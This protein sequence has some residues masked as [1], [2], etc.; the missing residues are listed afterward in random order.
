MQS[1]I[2]ETTRRRKLQEEFNRANGI[3]PQT[4]QKEIK[5]FVERERLIEEDQWKRIEENL[6]E[7]ARKKFK[8]QDAWKKAVEKAMFDAAKKLD[9]E[10]AATLRD[11]LKKKED[12][13]E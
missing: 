6:H 11:L 4:I 12:E 9:F 7:F 3:T 13:A 10:R 8:S 2:D 5:D 1:A